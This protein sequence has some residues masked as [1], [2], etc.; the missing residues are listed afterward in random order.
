MAAPEPGPSRREVYVLGL[1]ARLAMVEQDRRAVARAHAEEL[2]TERA[3][4]DGTK[5]TLDDTTK[6]LNAERASHAGTSENLENTRKALSGTTKALDEAR[7][8]LTDSRN[9]T[10]DL[11]KENWKLKEQL[12]GKETENARLTEQL[13][14]KN[15]G[16]AQGQPA[17]ARP[18]GH[19]I[20]GTGE[21]SGGIAARTV[22][23]TRQEQRIAKSERTYWPSAEVNTLIGAIVIG[24]TGSAALAHQLPSDWSAYAGYAA[25]IALAAVGVARKHWENRRQYG[26][27][28]EG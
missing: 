8:E 23:D 13:A 10:V 12:S 28:P 7:T 6:A 4:H 19:E 16:D 25:G 3:S 5:R 14:R 20:G 18:P 26:N 27:R 22:P 21:V 9:A 2:G 17:E 15:A 11:V 24:A 1:E